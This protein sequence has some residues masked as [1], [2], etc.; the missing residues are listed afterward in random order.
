[1]IISAHRKCYSRF[2]NESF[3]VDPEK[4]V[5]RV[6]RSP[7]LA[8][9]YKV[10]SIHSPLPLTKGLFTWREEDPSTRKILEGGSSICLLYS[11][12]MQKVVLGPSPRIFLEI[13]ERF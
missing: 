4:N 1:M 11:V 2:Y 8:P 6:R 10:V 9:L 7:S 13:R 12:Y 3:K 5:N